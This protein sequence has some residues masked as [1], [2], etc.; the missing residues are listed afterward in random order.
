[1]SQPIRF[2]LDADLS[3]RIAVIARGLG[4]DVVSAHEAGMRDAEDN[5]QLAHA[6][7]E[8][9]VLVTRNRDDFLELTLDAYHERK[10]HAGLLL[11]TAHGTRHQASRVA[12]ALARW[13]DTQ[14]EVVRYGV[15]WLKG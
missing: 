9:R 8:G 12:H 7:G 2:Y 4:L 15:Y 14:R 5:D 6:A 10:P 3:P 1:M 13:A 11:V